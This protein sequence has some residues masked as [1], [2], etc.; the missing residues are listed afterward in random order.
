M[1]KRGSAARLTV[2]M[3]SEEHMYLKMACA[4]IGITMREFMLRSAFEKM[5]ELEDAWLV[6]KATETLN[7][8]AAGE[9]KTHAWSK[10][11]KLVA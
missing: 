4:K 10:V 7:R 11:K 5:E 3:S 9:E 8:I 6:Q 2:D 1:A